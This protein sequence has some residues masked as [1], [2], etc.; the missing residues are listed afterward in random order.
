MIAKQQI[1]DLIAEKLDADGFYAVDVAVKP[2]NRI[3]ILIDSDHG[4]PIE[5]CVEISRLVEHSF[6]REEEDFELEVSSPGIGQ[7]FKVL[8]QYHKCLNRP[9]EVMD[10]DGKVQKGILEEVTDSGFVV[11]EEKMVKPEGKKKKELQVFHHQFSFDEVKR[12]K[13][14]LSL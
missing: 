14:I 12:V 2:G 3:E 13:E 1:M 10:N 6:D 5:Y 8:Q 7:P 9:V 4:V 11:K